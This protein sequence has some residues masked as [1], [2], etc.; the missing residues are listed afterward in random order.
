MSKIALKMFKSSFKVQIFVILQLAVVLSVSI[1]MIS[2]VYLRIR[3]YQP[4]KEVLESKASATLFSDEY[5]DRKTHK[6]IRIDYRNTG[7]MAED[8]PQDTDTYYTRYRGY[9]HNEERTL[10]VLTYCE[11]TY[12]LYEPNLIKGD[13]QDIMSS[14]LTANGEIPVVVYDVGYGYEI[15]DTFQ[16]NAVTYENADV[17]LTFKVCGMIGADENIF[18]NSNTGNGIHNH[19]SFYDTPKKLVQ[20]EL[21]DENSKFILAFASQDLIDSLDVVAYFDNCL[22][23][24][25]YSDDITNEQ[26]V[27]NTDKLTL[28]YNRTSENIANV[29]TLSKK[30]I[31]YQLFALLP[32][33]VC[34]AIMTIVSG[35]CTNAVSAKK[36]TRNFAVFNVCGS[37]VHGCVGVCALQMVISSAIAILLSVLAVTLAAKIIGFEIVINAY[38]V[39]CCIVVLCVN[40]VF[41]L[42]MPYRIIKSAQPKELLKEH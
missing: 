13:W 26:I 14:P 22:G 32:I 28:K 15:G 27:T 7:P 9:I 42:I 19:N 5:T 21:D 4:L 20:N 29:N 6:T 12:S 1:F 37:T 34:I 8:F 35:I 3:Y 36:N 2:S 39:L 41:T 11:N 25:R 33:A 24:I 23:I 30:Y 16:G 31:S 17:T 40:L 18:G 10:Q 38:S